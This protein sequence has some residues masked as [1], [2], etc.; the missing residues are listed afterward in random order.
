MASSRGSSRPRDRP[1]VSCIAGRFFTDWDTF[2]LYVR[3]ILFYMV[4]GL[5]NVCLKIEY[6]L[7]ADISCGNTS[8]FFC[9]LLEDF[10]CLISK[11]VPFEV[12]YIMGLNCGLT[13]DGFGTILS[14]SQFHHLWTFL[15]AQLV[16]NPPAMWE[17]W[18]R[19]LGWEDL[20][21]KGKFWPG[22]FHGLYSP[23]VSRLSNFHVHH[24]WSGNLTSEDC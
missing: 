9:C 1:H 19:Y 20:L 3:K 23:W 21:E 24:L 10:S 18:V 12:T 7:V 5:T 6:W 13:T 8:R 22:E 2:F 4:L 16:K 11:L 15:V 14:D 17:I